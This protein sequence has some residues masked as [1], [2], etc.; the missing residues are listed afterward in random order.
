MQKAVYKVRTRAGAHAGVGG[1]AGA[2]T[3]ILLRVWPTSSSCR[4]A[5]P[6]TQ[7]ADTGKQL[8]A[9][10]VKA[11]ARVLS[12]DW[13]QDFKAASAKVGCCVCELRAALRV[14]G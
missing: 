9:G 13:V 12:E 1:G 5:P 7:L 4:A 11:A 8:E 14:V 10:D 2:R 3:S 6:S